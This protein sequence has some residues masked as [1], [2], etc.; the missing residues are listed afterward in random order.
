MQLKYYYAYQQQ[1]SRNHVKN[2]T[3]EAV[4][5]SENIINLRTCD[6][7]NSVVQRIQR[8]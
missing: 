8:S 7:F 4:C 2:L 5:T 3:R 1:L 6:R